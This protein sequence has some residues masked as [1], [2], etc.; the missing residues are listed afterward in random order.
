MKSE[1]CPSY[2]ENYKSLWE[3]DP[4]KAKLEW[5]KNAKYG[6][7]IHYGLYSMLHS[8]EW[9]QFN[10]KIPVREYAKLKDHFTAHNFDA[11]FITDL[12][13]NAGMKYINLTSCH[14]EGFC[15]WDSK[16]ETFNSVNSPCGRDLVKEL[17][18]CC[19]RKGLGFFTYYTFMLNWRHPYFVTR[20]VFD[21]ARPA[22]NEPQPE[23][24]YK[25]KEDFKKYIDY[26]VACID[27]LLTNYKNIAGIWLDLIAAWF[28][29]G[30]EYIPINDIYNYI[31]ERHPHVLISWKQG[32]TGTED[33]ASPENYFH[34]L[35]E[36]IRNRF[37]DEG[38]KRA[39][40][41]FEGNKN[42]HNEVCTTIQH[43]TWG[44]NPRYDNKTVDELYQQLGDSTQNNCNLLLNV[45]PMADGSIHPN[46]VK[47]LLDLGERIK[48]DG[49]PQVG[50]SVK[51]SSYTLE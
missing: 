26:A 41:G 35:E 29:M 18:D 6:M 38:A 22:Y 25:N 46:H 39:R 49:F 1:K 5:F 37:G 31:R 21:V 47:I 3:V 36:T 44:F 7:F 40:I 42:K 10:E 4:K 48:N 19:E 51:T 30:D 2:L 11:D 28:A 24:L 15:M 16:I 13:V 43:G 32:A 20:D 33:F 45:G 23:Y 8:H 50:K 17:S 34:S 9:V 12:A 27:E 14:H